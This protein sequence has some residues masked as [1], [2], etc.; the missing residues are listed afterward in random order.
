MSG[1]IW[2]DVGPRDVFPEEFV[3]F[4]LTDGAIR[5]DFLRYHRDLVDA[6]WWQR[7][8]AAV[9]ADAALPEVL[10][11]PDTV[12]FAHPG[13]AAAQERRQE[14]QSAWS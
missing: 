2:Y 13:E 3:T 7:M 9:R 1:E 14:D 6:S 11:Y 4:L 12:R 5:D 8:Q 10:S